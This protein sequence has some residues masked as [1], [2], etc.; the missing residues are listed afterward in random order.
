MYTNMS[1]NIIVD[2]IQHYRANL[3]WSL[4]R[5]LTIL[6]ESQCQWLLWYMQN[7]NLL[8]LN[9]KWSYRCHTYQYKIGMGDSDVAYNRM[10][11]LQHLL[12]SCRDKDCWNFVIKLQSS[13]F[14]VVSSSQVRILHLSTWEK[15]SL[16]YLK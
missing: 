12:F 7:V 5:V 14:F 1:F 11:W 4:V 3:I 13:I 16:I 15:F 8:G 2:I 6:H 9:K 10:L